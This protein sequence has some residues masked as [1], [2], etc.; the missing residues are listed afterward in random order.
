MKKKKLTKGQ[1]TASVGGK[2]KRLYRTMNAAR[3]AK[4]RAPRAQTIKKL[5]RNGITRYYL[6]N[7]K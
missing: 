4:D 5:T 3:G 7:K 2:R 1:K 6:T